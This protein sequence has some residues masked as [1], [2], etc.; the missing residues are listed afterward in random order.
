MHTSGHWWCKMISSLIKV[1]IIRKQNSRS[2]KPRLEG[3]IRAATASV[4]RFHATCKVGTQRVHI[5]SEIWIHGRYIVSCR[6]FQN[7]SW[8]VEL[9]QEH[10][11]LCISWKG[12]LV[13]PAMVP[14][15][16]SYDVTESEVRA[17]RKNW[18]TFGEGGKESE[19]LREKSPTSGSKLFNHF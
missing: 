18:S 5:A 4:C 6:L 9:T 2:S 8:C 10:T 3:H 14:S 12:V 7:G 13:Q 17:Q 19:K 16:A 11:K 15:Q 1:R